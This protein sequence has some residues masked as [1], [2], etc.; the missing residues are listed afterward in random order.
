MFLIRFDTT[1][2]DFDEHASGATALI[3]AN[4]AADF[5][6]GEPSG[7]IR[8]DDGLPIG[9][10]DSEAPGAWA[11]AIKSPSGMPFNTMEEP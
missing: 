8:N 2:C 10:W 6:H 5:A 7:T 4:I 3:L 9:H 1:D 11:E